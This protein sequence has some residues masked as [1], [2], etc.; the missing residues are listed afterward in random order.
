MSDALKLVVLGGSGAFT[1]ELAYA[2]TTWREGRPPLRLVLHGR[3]AAKLARVQAACR[4]VVAGQDPSIAVEIETDSRRA[5]EGAG[6]VINQV[7]V[8]GLAARASDETFPHELGLPGEETVGAGGF[9]NALRTVPVALRQAAE[10]LEVAPHATLINLTNPASIVGQAFSRAGLRR[11]IGVC[12]GPYTL[13]ENVAALVGRAASDL[14]ISYAGVN[15]FG[16]VLAV[17]DGAQDLLPL[18]LQRAADLPKNEIDPQIMQAGGAIPNPYLR[19]LYHPER[20]LAAQR[21]KQ[22]RGAQ[23][24][25]VEAELLDEYA[26]QD[27]AGRPEALARR[28]A[29]WYHKVIVPVLDALVNDRRAVHVVNVRNGTLWPWLPPE[30]AVEVSAVVGRDGARPLAIE[31]AQPELRSLLI[32]FATYEQLAVEA[33]IS[34][35]RDTALRALLANPFIPTADQAEALLERVWPDGFPREI[36]A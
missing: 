22:A 2:L 24:Q 8:G 31:V 28:G 5:L 36:E 25:A 15:H 21:G 23:L 34:G 33:I 1:P 35:S 29:V 18:A 10:I 30:T 9:A 17:R 26:R 3:D 32:A 14:S 13:Q 12:D 19:Y 11:V 27:G 4:K 6:H 16:W 7:R 20:I